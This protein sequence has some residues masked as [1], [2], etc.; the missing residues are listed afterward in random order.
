MDAAEEVDDQSTGSGL[1][2]CIVFGEEPVGQ[3]DACAGTG[4]SF[5]HIKDGLARFSDLLRTEGSEDAM[6]DGV[7]QEQDFSR[8]DE[9]ADERENA[10]L[11][12]DLDAGC[13]E[14]QDDAHD[15]T[16]E[17]EADDGH[18]HAQDT[19]GEV[20]DEH[21][22]TRF[23]VSIDGGIEFLDDQAS[24]GTHDHG[25]HEHG[26]CRTADDA[27]CG[28][29]THDGAAQAADDFA[30]LESDEQGQDIGQEGADHFGQLFIGQ[31]AAWDE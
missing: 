6:V 2:G 28:D 19:D 16:D 13:Q 23:D 9:D 18:D 11:E 31:P 24:Q 3:E 4:I 26:V 14:G 15:R 20:V 12:Q 21:F 17:V 5:N 25:T 8:F 10:G 27:D 30:A 22:K 29:G 7:V 1:A